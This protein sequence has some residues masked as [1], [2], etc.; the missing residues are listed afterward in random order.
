MTVRP[1][2]FS[3]P[4]VRAIIDGRKSQTRRVLKRNKYGGWPY[5][6]AGQL[7]GE[8]CS[9]S[10]SA[11]PYRTGDLLWV[12]ETWAMPHGFDMAPASLD[13]KKQHGLQVAYKTSDN[14]NS[15][16]WRP[17]IHMPRW[18]SRLT[19]SV[20]AVKVERLQDIS[21]DDAKAEG[22][23]FHD[24]RGVGHSGWRHD[25]KDVHATA[26]CSFRRLWDSINGQREGA[27]WDENPWVVA[28]SF[29]TICANV[30]SVLKRE[31]A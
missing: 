10:T 21:E 31:A 3:G 14:P 20:D 24:G 28:I 4:M 18:A 17:G 1:I 12:R 30:D 11:T 19:L 5:Y 6:L 25:L 2:L 15:Y 27:S 23:S 29:E 16:S 26:K 9:P 8:Q 7:V 22:A 13:V